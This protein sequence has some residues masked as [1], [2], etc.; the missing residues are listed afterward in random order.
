VVALVAADDLGTSAFSDLDLILARQFYR[1]FDGLRS[2]TAEV[3]R[4]A[5]KVFPG[6]GKKLA[7]VA[8]G[9]GSAELATVN[10]FERTGLLG[11]G[12]DDL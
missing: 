4:A 6:E 11:H 5:T 9:N 8:F 3:N 1:A 10:K 2:T 12:R 7:R